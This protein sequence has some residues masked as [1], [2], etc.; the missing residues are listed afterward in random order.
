LSILLAAATSIRYEAFHDPQQIWIGLRR[1]G[2]IARLVATEQPE[3][4]LRSALTVI[5]A[6][7]VTKARIDRR[8]LANEATGNPHALDHGSGLATLV[9]AILAAAGVVES[10][11][12]PRE[13]WASV[14]VDYDDVVGGLTAIGIL[15][16]GWS[17]PPGAVVTLP[18]RVLNTCEWPRPD[19]SDSYVFVTENPSVTAAAADLAAIETGIRLLCTVGTPSASEISAIGQLAL[20]GWRVA[21]RADF[22][23]AG[24]GNVAAVLRTV[25]QAIPW[26]MGVE[27]YI[28][29]LKEQTQEDVPLNGVPDTPW[30]PDLSHAMRERR[31]A[32][33]EES[34]LTLLLEDLRHSAH[35]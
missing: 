34:L 3:R 15:P 35:A 24:I 28:N 33:F 25:P 27:D 16:V 14:G 26:R 20:S 2:V 29:S 21:V 8:R 22:D 19:I 9:I 13:A 17:A 4:Y 18:P 31:V 12:R 32:A 5:A 7:P 23:A 30:A 11:Q 1:G 6:L 10:R